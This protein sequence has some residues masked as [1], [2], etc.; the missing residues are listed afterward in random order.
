VFVYGQS[1]KSVKLYNEGLKMFQ[2]KQYQK[3]DSLFTLSNNLYPDVNTYYN[4][5]LTKFYLNDTCGFCNNMKVVVDNDDE[6]A[7]VM[8]YKLCIRH[9]TIK[10]GE[11]KNDTLLFSVVSTG[12]CAKERKQRFYIKDYK[13][14]KITAFYCNETFFSDQIQKLVTTTFPRFN[15][16]DKK[17]MYDVCDLVDQMPDFPGG[18]KNLM[19]FFAHNLIYP[20]DAKETGIQGEVIVEFKINETGQVSQPHIIKGI[21]GGC[22]EECVR[23]INLMPKWKPAM[24]NGV[25]ASVRY[26]MTLRYVLM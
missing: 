25:P 19:L 12:F 15:S 6:E 3:A 17:F 18:Q 16:A 8:F 23:V 4:L 9:D 10:F 7:A 21:G 5:G 24:T 14:Q 13:N 22:D 11:L 26:Q 1:N 2:E 20:Q